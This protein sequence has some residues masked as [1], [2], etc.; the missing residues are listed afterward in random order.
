[1]AFSRWI[2]ASLNGR[3]LTVFGDGSAVRDFTFV[4][5]VVFATVGALEISPETD[6]VAGK[7][8][9]AST[10]AITLIAELTDQRS[11]AS[12]IRLNG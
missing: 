5:D 9:A 6:N 1:M 4:G 8:P 2:D 7:S 10:K 3:S 12:G 11:T